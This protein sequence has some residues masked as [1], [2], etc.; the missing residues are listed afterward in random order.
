M[1]KSKENSTNILNRKALS[2]FCG[3][4]YALDLI[5]GRWNMN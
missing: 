1:S 2:E 3:V 4:T 5:G